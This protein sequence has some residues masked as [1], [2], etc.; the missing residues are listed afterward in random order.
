MT[1]VGRHDAGYESLLDE[2]A[3]SALLS[4]D[5]GRLDSVFLATFAPRE[6]CGIAD[7]VQS[8]CHALESSASGSVPPVF[9]PY[10]TGGEALFHALERCH[11]AMTIAE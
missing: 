11:A 1:R 5:P 9:G 2:C 4:L 6:L 7:P 10:R 8:L 3:A